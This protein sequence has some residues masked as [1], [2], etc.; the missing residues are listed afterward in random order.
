MLEVWE[1]YKVLKKK[2]NAELCDNT[3]L[4]WEISKHSTDIKT[5]VDETYGCVKIQS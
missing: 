1:Y 4:L 3:L 2:E 5:Q